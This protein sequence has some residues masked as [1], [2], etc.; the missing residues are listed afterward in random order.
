MTSNGSRDQNLFANKNTSVLVSLLHPCNIKCYYWEGHSGHQKELPKG[1]NKSFYSKTLNI[2]KRSS[3]C[4]IWKRPNT[5]SSKERG[6][7]E[8]PPLLEDC[9]AR[10][11]Q[12]RLADEK[13]KSKEMFHSQNL[14]KHWNFITGVPRS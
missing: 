4:G 14:A 9:P 6:K 12:I 2:W 1:Q 5:M 7:T 11:Y 3:Q 13:C 8:S 10:W